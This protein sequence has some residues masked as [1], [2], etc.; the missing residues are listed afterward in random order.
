MNKTSFSPFIPYPVLLV[1][2][3]PTVIGIMIGVVAKHIFSSF[4]RSKEEQVNSTRKAVYDLTE[5]ANDQT[6]QLKDLS[7]E[8]GD[9]TTEVEEA[10]YDAKVALH[11][12]N[13]VKKIPDLREITDSLDQTS[14][15]F[16]AEVEELDNILVEDDFQPRLNSSA[17]KS[18]LIG[19]IALISFTIGGLFV[20]STFFLLAKQ[21]D[22]NANFLK[23]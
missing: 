8:F 4:I 18:N 16:K 6:Y 15:Q 12:F 11:T 10:L 22:F 13:D 23:G 14:N 20:S 2:A 19:N 17:S 5:E 1:I 7:Q 9:I 3:A 21:N